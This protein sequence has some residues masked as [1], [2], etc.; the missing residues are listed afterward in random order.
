[1]LKAAG[2]LAIRAPSMWKVLSILVC[3]A[4]QRFLL[5]EL[6]MGSFQ[7][8]GVRYLL[9]LGMMFETE[10]MQMRPYQLRRELTIGCTDPDQLASCNFF[11]GTALINHNM[12]R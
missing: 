10:P 3:K 4:A 7:L 6:V 1:M 12:S 5:F 8:S 9:G 11:R 2:A